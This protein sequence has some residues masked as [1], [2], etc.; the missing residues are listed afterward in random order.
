MGHCQ[1]SSLLDPYAAVLR[2]RLQGLLAG[3]RWV[4]ADLNGSLSAR[5]LRPL[6]E[7]AALGAELLTAQPNFACYREGE[8]LSINVT[9][10]SPASRRGDVT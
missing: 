6:I 5:P 8:K 4:L 7:D 2:V 10:K 9:L 3:G 1:A